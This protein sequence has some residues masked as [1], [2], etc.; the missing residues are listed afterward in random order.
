LVYERIF[1]PL[2]HATEAHKMTITGDVVAAV[3]GVM[4]VV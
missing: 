4:T 1:L 2:D 3:K